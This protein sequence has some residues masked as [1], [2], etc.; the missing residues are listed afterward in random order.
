MTSPRV[1]VLMGV[2]NAERYLRE[3]VDSLLEQSFVDYEIVAVD[4]G[5]TDRSAELLAGYDDPRLRIVRN[6]ENLGLPRTLNV[7]LAAARGRLIAR[8]DADDLA[9]PRRLERQ[10]AEMADR[11]EIDVLGTWTTEIDEHGEEIGSFSYPPSE[12]LIRWGMARTN[13]VYHPTVIMRREILD[14]VGGYDEVEFAEDYDLFTRILIHGGRIDTLPERLVRYRRTKGQISARHAGKQRE[15]AR[16]IRR[17][18]IAWLTESEVSE[19][20]AETASALQTRT[21]AL[22]APEELGPAI[23]LQRAIQRGAAEPVPG[24]AARVAQAARPVLLHHAVR[25]RREGRV[26]NAASIW[27]FAFVSGKGW[28]DLGVLREGASVLRAAIRAAI[29]GLGRSFS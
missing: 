25:L 18:Y 15:Q 14:V 16:W 3:A 1:S 28:L 6:E 13:V 21:G 10:V 24:G 27:W 4:D 22:P 19:E 5:S 23:Q 20:L 11:P 2:Y 29:P 17:R 12:A 9:E 7:A 26:A 8:L